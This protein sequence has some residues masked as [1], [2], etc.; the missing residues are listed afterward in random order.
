MPHS[1]PI[2]AIQIHASEQARGLLDVPLP[3][4]QLDLLLGSAA[5]FVEDQSSCEILLIRDDS[6]CFFC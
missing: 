6:A 3:V 2:V 5:G 4:E 1:L